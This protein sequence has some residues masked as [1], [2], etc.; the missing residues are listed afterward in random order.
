M[1]YIVVLFKNKERKKIIKKFKTFDRAKKYYE[2]LLKSNDVIFDKVVEE[3]VVCNFE[4][5]LLEFNPYNHVP[6][7]IRDD[8]GRQ[9][10]AELDDPEYK[11]V[12]I[13]PY[14]LEELI[15]DVSKNKRLPFD[16][17]ISNYISGGSLKL[18]SKINNKIVVQNDDKVNLFTFKNESESFRFLGI[19]EGFLIDSGN[20]NCVIVYDTSKT[21]KKYIYDILGDLG[22]NKKKLYRKYTSFPVGK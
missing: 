10:K 6:I 2:Q 11:I 1:N 19:L 9:F 8:M 3:N 5:S 15:Y 7:F 17:F 4:L 21:Q 14:K 22:I 16:K 20:K 18:I 12:K 13:S